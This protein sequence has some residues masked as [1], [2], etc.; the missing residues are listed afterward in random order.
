[1]KILRIAVALLLAPFVSMLLAQ[2]P[3]PAKDPAPPSSTEPLIVDVHAS[4]YRPSLTY[5]VNISLQ[6]FDMRK[7]T[8]VNMIDFVRGQA[9]DH[10]REDN[11]IV[12][13]P[14]WIDL[15]RFDVAA[16]VPSLK[17]ATPIDGQPN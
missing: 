8:I 17:P 1:M 6:R 3:V 12:G 11:A 5:T 2:G 14:T 16:M 10:G 4:P 9:D 7:A 15:D 13:G